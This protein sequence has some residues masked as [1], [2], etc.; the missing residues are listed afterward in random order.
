MI[1]SAPSPPRMACT[2]IYPAST[3][4]LSHQRSAPRAWPGPA[5]PCLP[6]FLSPSSL[7][8]R[9]VLY[10]SLVK[11]DMTCQK[12]EFMHINYRTLAHTHISTY[13]LTHSCTH[14]HTLS[15]FF[16]FSLS[17]THTLP[18]SLFPSLSLS[19]P[20]PLFPSLS[21]SLSLSLWALTG[22]TVPRKD[23]IFALWVDASGMSIQ[24]HV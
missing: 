2:P 20:L 15:I 10:L 19:L 3:H 14:T 24:G 22:N 1:P 23:Y 9:H 7:L 16:T 11:K 12:R 4:A 8:R 13:A 18:L 21:L 5:D 6:P 17:L